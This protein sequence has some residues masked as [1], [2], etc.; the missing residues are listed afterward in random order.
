MYRYLS[1]VSA[2]YEYDLELRNQNVMPEYG[3]KKQVVHEF[4]DGGV[5]VT[6]M[7][8]NSLFKV[9]VQFT[10]VTISNSDILLDLWHDGAN[11][12]ANTFYWQHPATERYYTVRFE[13]IL[14]K[15]YRTDYGTAYIEVESFILRVE[16]NK[17]A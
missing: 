17:P 7:S 15:K 8:D 6:R 16:G 13:D 12:R 10:A 9:N 2:D 14:T 3:D 5:S 1:S 11:G 4:D